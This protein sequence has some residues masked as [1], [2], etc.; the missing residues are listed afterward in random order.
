MPMERKERENLRV[1]LNVVRNVTKTIKLFPFLYAIL[2][3]ALFPIVSYGSYE[4]AMFVN[5]IFFV[6]PLFIAFLILLSYFVK[7]C[8]WHRLQC[9][10][11]I[12]P[13]IVVYIDE[14]VYE[15]TEVVAIVNL[16]VMLTIF[17]LSLINA[18]FVFI[19]PTQKRVT[20][21][22][23]SSIPITNTQSSPY[24]NTQSS[25]P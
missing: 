19:K 20:F 14:N 12:I 3:L 25:Q 11:P 13:Q 24:A 9:L 16:V 8:N 10:L 22:T 2:L 7:L 15:L 4:I 5:E 6:S 21:N 23:Q 17:L 18:Y 1:I